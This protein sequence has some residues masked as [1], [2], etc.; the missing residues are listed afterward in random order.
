[1]RK[2]ALILFIM[3]VSLIA[4]GCVGCLNSVQTTATP[5]AAPT[6]APTT[7]PTTPAQT[8]TPTTNPSDMKIYESGWPQ[9]PS[10]GQYLA[11]GVRASWT[12]TYRA[13][14]WSM[15]AVEPGTRDVSHGV[16]QEI[17]FWNPTAQNQTVRSVN[18]KTGFTETLDTP[19]K[20]I[21]SFNDFHE[22]DN[23]KSTD[24][25]SEFTMV[26]GNRTT[27]LLYSY[28]NDDDFAKYNGYIK[29]NGLTIGYDPNM[30]EP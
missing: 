4:A 1:M 26:P 10:Q 30:I 11:N 18:F 2:Y 6:V 14:D 15:P 13:D 23:M 7:A 22:Y 17:N 24:F 28:I 12:R 21:N 9:D 20:F 29:P 19:N 27:V 16:V 5:T 8:A 3:L 25:F